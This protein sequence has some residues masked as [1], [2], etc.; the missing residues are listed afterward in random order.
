[1]GEARV[2]QPVGNPHRTPDPGNLLILSSAGP[3]RVSRIVVQD[4]VR[5]PAKLARVVGPDSTSPV[6]EATRLCDEQVIERI[7]VAWVR[8]W[9]VT[10]FLRKQRAHPIHGPQ[11]ISIAAQ[12]G[13]VVGPAPAFHMKAAVL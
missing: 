11:Y 10:G 4:F 13:K 9:H 1:M 3:H 5:A 6:P 2:F 12:P 7:A 8:C